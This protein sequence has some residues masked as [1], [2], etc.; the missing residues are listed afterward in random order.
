MR[1][2]IIT[3]AIIWTGLYPVLLIV[4]SLLHPFIGSWHFALKTLITTLIVVPVM[5]FFI[6]PLVRNLFKILGIV[7]A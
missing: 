4:S 6:I 7:K 2:K 3:S 5:V 1:Q